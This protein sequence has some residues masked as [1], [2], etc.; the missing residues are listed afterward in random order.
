MKTL[1]DNIPIL[2]LPIDEHYD[3]LIKSN[4]I[5]IL[6]LEPTLVL[7]GSQIGLNPTTIRYTNSI[8]VNPTEYKWLEKAI[9]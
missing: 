5:N 3:L 4:K 7:Q 6:W 1:V 2:K 8:Y 9:K